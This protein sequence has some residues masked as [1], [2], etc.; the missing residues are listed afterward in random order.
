MGQIIGFI[1]T[2]WMSLTAGA[3]AIAAIVYAVMGMSDQSVEAAMKKKLGE[4]RAAE[5]NSLKS[6][7]RNQAVIDAEAEKGRQFEEA[8][9]ATLATA[10]EINGR[11]PLLSDVFPRVASQSTAF[12]FTEEYKRKMAQLPSLINADTLPTEFDIEEEQRNVEDLQLALREKAEEGGEAARSIEE[13]MRTPPA[14][15]PFGPRASSGLIGNRGGASSTTPEEPKFNALLRAQ[16]TKARSMQLYIGP[17]GASANTGRGGGG[18]VG[19]GSQTEGAST[20]H[21]APITDLSVAPSET[22]LWQAQVGY[23]LQH[24]IV[25]AIGQMNN[26]AAAELG[27]EEPYVGNMPVKHLKN[28]FI[29]GYKSAEAEAARGGGSRGGAPGGDKPTLTFP[30]VG[31]NAGN[32]PIPTFTDR[33]SNDLYDVMQFTVVVVL[34]QRRVLDFVD[35]MSRINLIQLVEMRIEQVDRDAAAAAGYLY[36]PDPVVEATMTFELYMLRATYAPLMPTPVKEILG[37]KTE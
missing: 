29:R 25:Q 14:G 16:V 27:D 4:L 20:F 33:S 6:K 11:A 18:M 26:A 30:T 12:Q 31:T 17:T 28:V 23:W 3:V 19:G 21:I 1:K 32:D 22:D 7:P 2:F 24:D 13:S 34:D 10:A 15:N 8:Y 9:Q 36:G 5:I 37:V 35:A